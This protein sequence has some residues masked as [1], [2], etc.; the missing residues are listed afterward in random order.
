MSGIL[1]VPCSSPPLAQLPCWPTPAVSITAV[2]QPLLGVEMF[3]MASLLKWESVQKHSGLN[4]S[5]PYTPATAHHHPSQYHPP[6]TFSPPVPEGPPF[7]GLQ[8][9]SQLQT[10]ASSLSP[11]G[12]LEPRRAQ[13][14]SSAQATGV[15]LTTPEQ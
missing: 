1:V 4:V 6:K 3:S 15:T 8:S 11:L 9:L 12:T 13:P 14:P 7:M 5:L 2:H 10:W